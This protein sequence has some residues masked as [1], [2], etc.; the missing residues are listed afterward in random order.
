MVTLANNH[1]LDFGQEGLV[2]TL[3][4]AE[5]PATGLP[6]VGAGHDTAEA[7]SAFRVTLRGQRISILG[8]SRV[9]DGDLIDDW[10]VADDRPGIAVAEDP[11][12]LLEAVRAERAHGRHPDR[13]PPL[14]AGA[15]EL[16]HR[17]PARDG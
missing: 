12:R 16:P 17:R 2:D 1:G 9:T 10:T 13:L 6:L 3:D 4:A 7:Y 15:G 8:A 14:G 11:T 5:D